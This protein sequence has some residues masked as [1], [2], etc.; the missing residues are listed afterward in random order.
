LLALLESVPVYGIELERFATG[1]RFCLLTTALSAADSMV[2]EPVLSLYC[3]LAR[4]CFINNYVFAQSDQEIAQVRALR[5]AVD[6]ALASGVDIPALSL[7]AAAAYMPL[8]ALPGAETLLGRPWPKA[9]SDLLA[10]QVGAPIEERRL[11]ATMPALTAI[12]DDVSMQVRAQYE[13]N[14]Y[15]Q[16]IKA[17][18]AGCPKTV[19]SLMREEFPASPFLELNNNGDLAVLVAGCGTGRHSILAARRFA[20]ARVLA[21]DISLTSLCYAQRRTRALGLDNIQ[22]AQADIMKLA[23]IGRTF[24][25]IEACGVL[26]H[27]ADPLAGWR[28][29]L[30]LLR[31]GGIMLLGFYSEIAR[32][33]IVAVRD[34]IAA[35]GYRPTAD[36]IRRCR[37]ELFEGADGT[38]LRNVTE[39]ADFFSL[40]ECRDLLFHGQEHRLTL[41]RIA[42]FLAENDLQLLGFDVDPQ[43]KRNYAKQFPDDVVM[44]DLA[45]WHRYET[46]NPSA[47]AGMYQFWVQKKID[48]PGKPE[49]GD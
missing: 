18:P 44:T 17:D 1:L 19:D 3:A 29:L 43:T 46:D 30:S 34:F 2:A 24:D 39:L 33:D 9:V 40:S 48:Q 49:G 27:L 35:R 16:W 28:V 45:L 42:A 21:I 13:E 47:F 37:Q 6:A 25:V 36:D 22:Y 38:P 12:D 4:Q 15:P 14:P 10:Q 20:A 7:V 31:P 41:P 23:S 11:R 5:D 26:H 32:R 8:H